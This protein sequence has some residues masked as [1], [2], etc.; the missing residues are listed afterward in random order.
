M[1]RRLRIWL[2][3]D[4]AMFNVSAISGPVNRSRRSAAIVSIRS[5]GV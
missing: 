5:G 4:S 1:P 2:T 3:V